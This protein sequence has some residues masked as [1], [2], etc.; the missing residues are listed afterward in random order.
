[1]KNKRKAMKGKCPD[2]GTKMNQNGRTF[3]EKRRSILCPNCGTQMLCTN[4]YA[5]PTKNKDLYVWYVCP[6][7]KTRGENGCGHKAPV[8]IKRIGASKVAKGIL[9]EEIKKFSDIVIQAP[10]GINAVNK[11]GTVTIWNRGAELLYGINAKDALGKNI[12]D[13]PCVPEDRKYEKSMFIKR[14][15]DGKI[16]ENY[17]TKR[18]RFD[19]KD[20]VTFDAMLSLFPLRDAKGDIE[21]IAAFTQDISK[22]KEYQNQL[23]QSDRMTEIG[24]LAAGVAHE[25]NNLL[26][27]IL[28]YAQY[29]KGIKAGK[30]IKEALDIIVKSSN[31]GAD[32]VENLLMFA[33]RIENKKE[34]TD[35]KETLEG[36]MYLVKRDLEKNGI[37]IVRNYSEISKT[38]VDIGQ[39]QQVFLNL[40]IDAQEAMPK[41]GK[42]T[43]SLSQDDGFIKIQFH[44]TGK[45]IK[46]KDLP[47]LFTPFFTTK[48]RKKEGWSGTGLGLSVSYGII[49]AH[50]G[51][52]K[53]ESEKDK[54]TTFTVRLPIKKEK[55]RKTKIEQGFIEPAEKVKSIVGIVK[56]ADILIVDDEKDFCKLLKEILEEEGHSV[57]ITHSGKSAVN[58]CKRK[59]FDLIFM[60]IVMPM[61]DGIEAFKKISKIDP[62]AKMVFITGKPIEDKITKMYID[63]GAIGFLKKP[64]DIK[65]ILSYIQNILLKRPKVKKS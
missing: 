23:I 50:G 57:T 65:K 56:K 30:E 27:V 39:I 2:C 51:T 41:G 38:I 52:I 9:D 4:K 53:V 43:I 61:M 64:I 36:V 11:K 62:D 14:V 25:F 31:R 34:L 46:K 44:D 40:I 1:M 28:G 6:R 29:A 15:L 26:N 3:T 49:Q 19:G 7:R 16:I 18:I 22:E 59:H 35:I 42:L 58:L 37:N 60:D 55:I 13:F 63:K 12:A 45:I 48:I 10:I 47:R 54:G 20:K 5:S 17:E 33:K 8:E 24:M 21:N 32:I